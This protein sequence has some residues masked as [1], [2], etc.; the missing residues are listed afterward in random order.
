VQLYAIPSG[1]HGNGA[2]DP[3]SSPS[4]V[5]FSILGKY[6]VASTCCTHFA[7]LQAGGMGAG[8]QQSSFTRPDRA[9]LHKPPHKPSCASDAECCG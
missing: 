7:W 8:L 5:R 1:Y 2:G 6:C 9:C 3:Y 4:K